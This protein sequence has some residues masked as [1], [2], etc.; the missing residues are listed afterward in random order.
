M[1]RCA[2][3]IR[4]SAEHR[5]GNTGHPLACSS[6]NWIHFAKDKGVERARPNFCAGLVP[7]LV[8]VCLGTFQQVVRVGPSRP[9]QFPARNSAFRAE[10]CTGLSTN[11]DPDLGR[12]LGCPGITPPITRGVPGQVPLTSRPVG[13][14]SRCHS[15]TVQHHIVRDREL[16]GV[17]KS[18]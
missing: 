6:S 5:L 12:I 2:H 16:L 4:I 14:L 10:I 18:S 15:Q 13:C 7:E 8:H 11:F 17:D 9:I 3:Y 1:F